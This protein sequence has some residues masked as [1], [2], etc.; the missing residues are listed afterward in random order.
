MERNSSIRN[1]RKA[2]RL[3]SVA[4]ALLLL[5]CFTDEHYELSIAGLATRLGLAKSTVHR[6]ASTL[7]EAGMVEQNSENAKYRLGLTLFE[8][9]SLV[10]RNM[11]I[12]NEAKSVL[13]E[14]RERTRET[15][16]LAILRDDNVI[17]LNSLESPSSIKV[18]S[19]LG[20]RM[21]AHCSA[22]GK[23][24]LAF[25]SLEDVDRII[26]AGFLRRTPQTVVN[27]DSLHAELS[28]IRDKQYAVDNEENETGVRAI[29]AP[30]FGADNE[31]VAAV[32]V[33]GP[34]QRLSQRILISFLPS[35]RAG[36]DGISSRLGATRPVLINALRV[37]RS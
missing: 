34:V 23:V 6:L 17:Y 22:E 3:S 35:L 31:V 7:V 16:N 1:G 10:R 28:L 24:L 29:A 30:V 32:S 37:V 13:H 19:R 14:L 11:N 36:V 20:V 5:K 25:S 15:V 8:L 26:A 21:C 2:R 27:P 33:A 12:Y 18:T 9:G 4:T